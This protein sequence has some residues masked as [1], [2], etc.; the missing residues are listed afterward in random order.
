MRRDDW[1][2]AQLPVGMVEDEFF[3]RF[4]SI[5]QDVATTVLDGVDNIDYVTDTTVNPEPM[6]QW[7]AEWIGTPGLD[8][9]LPH[10]TQRQIVQTAG[11]MLASRGTRHGLGQ[12][13]QLVSGGPV[14]IE[15]GGGVYGEGHAPS[16]AAWVRIRVPSTGWLTDEDFLRLVIDEVPAHVAAE[17]WVADRRL[18]PRPVE[19]ADE[20]RV[21]SGTPRLANEEVVQP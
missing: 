14:S 6:V 10:G 17:I 1:L 21:L 4:V 8:S 5:F 16:D 12:F 3:R 2:L 19:P 7:M 13:L 20:T 11:R 9:T 15:D 18:W